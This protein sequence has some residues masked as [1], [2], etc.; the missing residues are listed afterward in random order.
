MGTPE[1]MAGW[2]EV[3]VATWDLGLVSEV[4]VVLWDGAFKPVG[5]VQCGAVSVR[6]HL[7]QGVAFRSVV[8]AGKEYSQTRGECPVNCALKLCFF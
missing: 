6:P 4:G 3:E 5:S 1:F 2:S 7:V 8:G